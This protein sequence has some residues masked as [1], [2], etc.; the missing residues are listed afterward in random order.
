MCSEPWARLRRAEVER[1][2][3]ARIS[4]RRCVEWRRYSAAVCSVMPQGVVPAGSGD[5]PRSRVPVLAIVGAEDPQDP[6]SNLAG[7]RS[8]LPNAKTVVVAGAGHGSAGLGCVPRLMNRFL[9]AGSTTAST[10]AAPHG[11]DR[12]RSCCADAPRRPAYSR[13]AGGTPLGGSSSSR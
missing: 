4:T 6:L 12:R 5:T 7:L 1:L 13:R 10:A 11:I 3:A 9:L 8:R 2:A